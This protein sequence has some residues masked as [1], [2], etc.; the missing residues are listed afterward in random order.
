MSAII[1]IVFSEEG[2]V[3]LLFLFN[4]NLVLIYK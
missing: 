4:L 1:V 3:K 2:I